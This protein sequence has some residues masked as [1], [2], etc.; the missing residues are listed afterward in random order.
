MD[1]GDGK[2]LN[3]VLYS[4]LRA[5][6][7]RVKVK[8]KGEAMVASPYF[9]EATRRPRLAIGHLGE[10]YDVCCPFCGD[11][12]FRLSIS[13]R[14]GCRGDDGRSYWF[15]AYCFNEDC[16]TPGGGHDHDLKDMV[17]ARGLVRLHEAPLRQGVEVSPENRV[18][19]PPGPCR[20]LDA[21]PYDHRACQYL[22]ARGYDPGRL[23][24]AYGVAYCESSQWTHAARRIVAPVVIGG[25]LRG[26][27]ARYVGELP[28]KDP[29]RRAGLPPKWYTDP[30]M[31]TSRWLYNLDTASR[32]RTGVIVEGL[33]DVWGFGPMA[34][35]TFGSSLSDL[36]VKHVEQHWK[37]D[38][39]SVVLLWDPDTWEPKKNRPEPAVEHAIAKLTAAF[40]KGQFAAVRLPDGA[41]PGSFGRKPVREFVEDE[42]AK[43]GVAVSWE[44]RP[45]EPSEPN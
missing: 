14:Y 29:A 19:V 1:D 38:G 23:A 33:G 15:L 18:S 25:K 30:A 2:P 12:R 31:K 42:A 10:Y 32:F 26:W 21:L 6:F 40:P 9:D 37:R 8:N 3:P 13:H 43:Q 36:Q 20:R 45:E 35:G 24:R 17:S 39:C 44:L 11:Q 16:L 34:A 22:R 28:W 27:Q 7:G 4:R 5:L 41:D